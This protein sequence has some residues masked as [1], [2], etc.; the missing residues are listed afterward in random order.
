MFLIIFENVTWEGPEF[1][2]QM[3]H[4]IYCVV[5][6]IFKSLCLSFSLFIYLPFVLSL[7]LFFSVFLCSLI[8]DE[9]SYILLPSNFHLSRKYSFLFYLRFFE[10]ITG[11][12]QR[13]RRL[14]GQT[15]NDKSIDR[16]NQIKQSQTKKAKQNK[17]V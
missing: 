14:T 3:K 8:L 17:F 2:A 10:A 16:V 13:E 5:E 11:A 9:H 7:H 6:F 1:R 12:G 15:A 4:T